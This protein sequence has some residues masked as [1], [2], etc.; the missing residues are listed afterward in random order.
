MELLLLTTVVP[1]FDVGHAN[2]LAEVV[3]YVLGMKKHF[4]VLENSAGNSSNDEVKNRIHQNSQLR[5]RIA[6][7]GTGR[8]P[9]LSYF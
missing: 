6:S 3:G 9:K 1:V 7:P 5:G 8:V 2:K 4:T